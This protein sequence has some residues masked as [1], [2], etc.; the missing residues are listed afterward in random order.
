MW[1]PNLDFVN[2]V[3]YADESGT[4]DPTGAAKGAREAVMAGIVASRE[5]WARFCSLWQQVL[6]KYDAPY[7]HFC[8]WSDA[9]SV[10]RKKR[11]PSSSFKANPYRDWS[12]DTLNKF[13]IDLARLTGAGNNL[14][15]TAGVLT[16]VFHQEKQI[17]NIPDIANPYEHC[18]GQFFTRVVEA[19]GVQRPPWKRQPIS[20]FFDQSDDHEWTNAIKGQ[21]AT[22]QKRHR[23]FREIAF[24][25]KKLPPHLP[26]QAADMVAY[27]TRQMTEKWVDENCPKVWEELDAALFKSTFDFLDTRKKE[28]SLADFLGLLDHH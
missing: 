27:R 17:G 11:S 23:T 7:F 28:V 25:D 10:A 1:C 19:I 5:D 12:T 9:S 4:H 2:L 22:H 26:L 15:I 14:L 18:A 20:F 24:A 13:L 8:E 3:I 6:E 16:N 21:F